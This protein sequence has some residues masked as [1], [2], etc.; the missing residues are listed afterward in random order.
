MLRGLS[1]NF[2]HQSLASLTIKLLLKCGARLR[3]RGLEPPWGPQGEKGPLRVETYF[4]PTAW[5]QRKRVKL[6]CT[7][8][9]GSPSPIFCENCAG[10]PSHEFLG[11]V[12]TFS[13]TSLAQFSHAHGILWCCSREFLVLWVLKISQ[14]QNLHVLNFIVM[15]FPMKK[16]RVLGRFSS[17][18]PPI[19]LSK[20]AN[21][22]FIVSSLSL[23]NNR[24]LSCMR[25]CVALWLSLFQVPLLN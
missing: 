19:P 25:A 22:I 7:H 16:N 11:L 20:N 8:T 14:Q 5:S 3:S 6:L 15:A 10:S 18:S 9:L 17:L 12:G 2:A 23:S 1:R 24:R 13:G 4:A 21:F